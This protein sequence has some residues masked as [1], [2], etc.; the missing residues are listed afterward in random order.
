MAGIF[1][2]MA[3][4]TKANVNELLS[5]FEDPEKMVDQAILDALKEYASVKEAAL[6]V[7]ANETT[8]KK[9]LARLN[10]EADKWHRIAASALKAGNEDDARKALSNE[11][12]FRTEAD[13]QAR[14]VEAAIAAAEKLREKLALMEQEINDMKRKAAQIK[15]T[16]ATA[17]ATRA[18]AQVAAKSTERGGFEAF[19][20]MEEKANQELAKAQALESLNAG[21]TAGDDADL[22]AKYGKEAKTDDALEALRKELGL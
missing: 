2:R 20:R 3:M 22:E 7:L 12:K 11:N 13:A 17:K 16:A 15:A 10:E 8:A 6:P 9:E 18:A 1:E 21:Q 19:S 4:I 14:T 5:R